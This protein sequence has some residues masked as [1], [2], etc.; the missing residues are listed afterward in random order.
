[1]I[2]V[3]VPALTSEELSNSLPWVLSKKY[4]D[5]L[6]PS[7]AKLFDRPGSRL[8]YPTHLAAHKGIET[9]INAASLLKARGERLSF[10]ITGSDEDWPVGMRRIRRQIDSLGL[11]EEVLFVGRV[12]QAQMG[13]VFQKMDLMVYPSLC[14]SFGFSMVEAI[15]YGLPIVAADTAVNREMCEDAACYYPPLDPEGCA[16]AIFRALAPKELARLKFV[17]Q[18]RMESFIWSWDKYAK[19]FVA[20]LEKTVGRA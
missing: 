2:R 5:P 14:E 20:M 6:E 17:G 16:L 1:M 19:A 9:L 18:E 10:F 7:Q 8:L 12:P 4:S 15:G 11:H 13:S 3:A